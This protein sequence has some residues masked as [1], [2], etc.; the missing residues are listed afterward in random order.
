MTT[1]SMFFGIIVTMY[2]EADGRHHLPHV[3]VRCAEYRC[4]VSLDGVVLSGSLPPKKLTLLQAWM[5]LH[6]D[7]LEANWTLMTEGYDAYKIE[8]LS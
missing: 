3:H 6:Y 4:A 1:L 7:E 8:P 5:V 2:N